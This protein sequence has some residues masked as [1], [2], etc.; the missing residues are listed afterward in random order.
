MTSSTP[1]VGN[2]PDTTGQDPSNTE[3]ENLVQP[4]DPDDDVY[5]MLNFDADSGDTTG[6]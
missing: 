2:E 5:R 1:D 6:D 3:I 4:L